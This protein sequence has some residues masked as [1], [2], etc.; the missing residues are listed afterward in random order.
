[1]GLPVEVA[2]PIRQ[3]K[4]KFLQ[5]GKLEA[6]AQLARNLGGPDCVVL[7]LI[8]A[9]D[10]DP[11]ALAR[12]LRARISTGVSHINCSITI[13]VKEF[14]SWF[15]G[16]IE[17]LRGQRGVSLDATAPE[18]SPDPIRGAKESLCR[19]MPASNPYAENSHQ[20]SF[21]SYFDMEKA[22]ERSPSFA[23]FD[24]EIERLLRRA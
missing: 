10:D 15:I 18:R 6:V 5:P 19:A 9:D 3:T 24:Q 23:A 12:N 17:G 14:E 4:S 7:V 8:D 11:D 16:G 20:A 1:M 13:A 2:S 22:R 21:A